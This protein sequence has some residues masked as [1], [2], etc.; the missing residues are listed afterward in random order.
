[1]ENQVLEINNK[2]HIE[3]AFKGHEVGDFGHNIQG[4]E[5]YG[6]YYKRMVF[7]D[8]LEKMNQL[9][10]EFSHVQFGSDNDTLI[11]VV[12]VRE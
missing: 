3:W 2:A 4:Q 9:G 11:I 6:I 5:L 12:A 8:Q 7:A 1:M 10:L